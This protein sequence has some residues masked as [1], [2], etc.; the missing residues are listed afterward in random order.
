MLFVYIHFVIITY[1]RYACPF[2]VFN[3]L[4]FSAKLLCDYFQSLKLSSI[5]TFVQLKNLKKPFQPNCH[6]TLPLKGKRINNVVA[7][8]HFQQLNKKL[9][10]HVSSLG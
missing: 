7:D 2:W 3:A 1:W 10:E 9:A 4:V 6:G 5:E 8:Q